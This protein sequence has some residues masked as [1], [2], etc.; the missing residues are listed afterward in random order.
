[1][2]AREAGSKDGRQPLDCGNSAHARS[3]KAAGARRRHAAEGV[4]RDPR[5]SRQE[6]QTHRA[7]GPGRAGT[8]AR[9]NA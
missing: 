6:R 5:A 7:E 1:M 8:S 2:S 3:R 9:K 4:D